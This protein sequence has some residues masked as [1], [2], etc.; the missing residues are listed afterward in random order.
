MTGAR[1]KDNNQHAC[2]QPEH[3]PVFPQRET[4]N[5][6]TVEYKSSY[7]SKTK[8]GIRGENEIEKDFLLREITEMLQRVHSLWESRQN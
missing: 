1:P 2:P 7:A 4:L 5:Q 3:R 8:T 6:R